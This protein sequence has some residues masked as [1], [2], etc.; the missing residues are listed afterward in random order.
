MS[1]GV[2]RD[3]DRDA[4]AA[5][6]SIRDALGAAELPQPDQPSL[7]E[8]GKPRAGVMIVPGE[9]S[10]GA[11]EDLCLSAVSHEPA[12]RC[13]DLYFECLQSAG[14]PRPEVLSK[15]KAQ[16]FLASKPRPG[17]RLGEAAEAGYWNLCSGAYDE[18]RRFLRLLVE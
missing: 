3:A 9:K 8:G 10:G 5:F 16:A 4:R 18:L 15:A 13:V 17:L 12:M 14:I 7:F 11:L 2:V 1:L 6:Q